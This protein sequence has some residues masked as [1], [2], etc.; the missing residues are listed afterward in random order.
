MWFNKHSLVGTTVATY[1]KQP[2]LLNLHS[3]A[4]LG[5]HIHL[6]PA[7]RA[8][9]LVIF[10]FNLATATELDVASAGTSN[11]HYV[12]KLMVLRGWLAGWLA[13]SGWLVTQLQKLL[14]CCKG[15]GCHILQRA[16][17]SS[18]QQV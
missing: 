10:C 5:L 3:V 18:W 15:C 12:L 16:G 4:H 9:M 11:S 17:S 14:D 2:T 7:D 13:G 1:L 8:E 6:Q